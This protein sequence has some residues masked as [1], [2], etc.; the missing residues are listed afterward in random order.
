MA[1]KVKVDGGGERKDEGKSRVDLLPPDALIALGEVY[2]F[3]CEKYAER[4]W[5]RGMPWSKVLGP[6][7][8]HT[9]KFMMGYDIDKESG[10]YHAQHIAWNAVALLTYVLRQIGKDDRHSV[11]VRVELHYLEKGGKGNGETK[12]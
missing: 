6:M 2:A 1:S 5:E 12:K 7:L 11:E 9:Y 10:L 4:N 8:R 3:G